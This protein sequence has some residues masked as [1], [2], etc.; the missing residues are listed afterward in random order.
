MGRKEVG[1]YLIGH[2]CFKVYLLSNGKVEGGR[3]VVLECARWSEQSASFY[4]SL[5]G[6]TRVE[7]LTEK[8]IESGERWGQITSF[9]ENV[10][11][12]KEGEEREL[13]PILNS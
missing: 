7:E 3:H 4:A 2:C 5:G 8:I 12:K 6:I 9:I 1:Q 11:S 13:K 10:M